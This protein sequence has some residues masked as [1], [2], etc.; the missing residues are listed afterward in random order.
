MRHP[1]ASNHGARVLVVR[2]GDY[3]GPQ[4]ANSW[5]SQGLVKPGRPVAAVSYPGRPGVGHQWA[6]LPDVAR[7]MIELLERCDSLQAFTAF[8][9]AGHWD[10]DGSQMAVSIRWVV[11]RRTGREPQITTFPWW[12]IVLASPFVATFREMLEMRYLWRET[13]RM[14]N[15]RLTA[16]LGREPHTPLDEAVEATLIGLGCIE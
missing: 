7:T 11:S 1:A 12:L 9:M 14:D 5:F 8:H 6:C 4:A 15:A 13:L 10:A 16:A 2:A 3:F